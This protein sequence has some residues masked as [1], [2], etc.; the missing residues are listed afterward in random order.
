MVGD[1]FALGVVDLDATAADPPGVRGRPD[2]SC[3]RI[4]GQ[5]RRL[6]VADGEEF[7]AVQVVLQKPIADGLRHPYPLALDVNGAAVGRAN[8]T[9]DVQPRHTD[10]EFSPARQVAQAVVVC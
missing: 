3:R 6:D 7:L 1:A 10:A 4:D 9:A 2:V 8:L 5:G